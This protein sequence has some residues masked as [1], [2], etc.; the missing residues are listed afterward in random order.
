MDD[1]KIK[2]PKLI[3]IVNKIKD[4]DKLVVFTQYNR[5]LEYMKIILD[6][7]EIPY[8]FINGSMPIKKRGKAIYDFQTDDNIKIFILTTKSANTGITLTSA[9]NIVFLEPCTNKNKYI[10]AIG[11]INRLGQRKKELNVYTLISEHSIEPYIDNKVGTTNW[12]SK[13]KLI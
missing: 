3:W 6:S 7:H 12:L 4:G 13:I 8:G 2:V 10:Q 11:R 5:V 9:S 1:E